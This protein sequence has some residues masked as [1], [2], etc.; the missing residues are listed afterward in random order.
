ML[1]VYWATT[2]T[3]EPTW[4]DSWYMFCRNTSQKTTLWL[5]VE[6]RRLVRATPLWFTWDFK[7]QVVFH[8]LG[9]FGQQS[10]THH[11]YS[12]WTLSLGGSVSRLNKC[13]AVLFDNP[14]GDSMKPY[15][16]TWVQRSL[17]VYHT[18]EC[19][20][21][22]AHLYPV[23]LQRSMKR[24][25]MEDVQQTYPLAFLAA[26]PIWSDQR[27]IRNFLFPASTKPLTTGTGS[28]GMGCWASLHMRWKGQGNQ[29]TTIAQHHQYILCI[30]SAFFSP[31][32]LMVLWCMTVL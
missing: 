32:L 3:G 16:D 8:L 9:S 10:A 29:N 21:R 14:L 23:Q 6:W 24:D 26:H 19:K 17:I 2:V 30:I 13:Q 4:T 20:L 25:A 18:N 7:V 1:Q 12:W 5:F 15:A 22:Q 27:P 31:C 28:K 11:K